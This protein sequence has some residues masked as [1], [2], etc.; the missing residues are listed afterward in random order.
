MSD[1]LDPQA[2][3]EA[4]AWRHD[5]H[6]HPELGFAEHRTA[7]FIAEKLKDWGYEVETGLART[8]VVASLR[9][10][11]SARAI[12]IRADIDALPITEESGVDWASATPGRMHACGHDGHTA[13]AL[14]AAKALAAQDFDGTVRF[15]FQ[16]AEEN[17]GGG[18][19]MVKEGLFARFP[20]DAVYGAHNWPGAKPGQIIARDD[21]MMAAFGT[22]EITVT[23]KGAH[24]A[25]PHEGEDT[26]LATAQIVT[27]LQSICARNVSPL[28]SAVVS[29]TQIHGGEA[30]NVLPDR[31]VIRGTTRWFAPEVGDRI[32]QRMKRIASS[33]A[34]GFGCTAGVD[35]QRRYPA[36]INTAR[37][38][39][40][41]REV[42]A[43]A[44]LA[45]LDADPSMAAEDFAFMLGEVP[46]C[47]FWIGAGREGDNPG[48][49]SA[50]FDFNDAILGPGADLWV[51]LALAELAPRA[52]G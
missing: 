4:K 43:G 6:R 3:A 15:I 42:A 38:A 20:V 33:V 39:A 49:H 18:R 48:L 32:E 5:L 17:E 40:I 51:R 35:Y 22:F 36:T 21:A 14:A 30:W 25:M 46:G 9:K 13:M 7:E 34:E 11:H 2:V 16:P 44:G 12:G 47:Y 1:L 19:E 24:G 26:L 41:V 50:R 37:N 31:A 8:G 28:Q 23:G 45:V 52:D 29:V 27:A 10:G